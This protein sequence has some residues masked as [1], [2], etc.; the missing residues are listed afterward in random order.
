[1][2]N[3][4]EQKL[5]FELELRN[6]INRH[7]KENDS[8]TPDYILA[9]YIQSSLNVFNNIVKQRDA[10]YGFNSNIN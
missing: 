6:L 3:P 7:S 1:M 2:N 8:N 5:T 4:H 10:W 9:E